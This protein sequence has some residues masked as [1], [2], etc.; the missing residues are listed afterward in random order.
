MP[1]DIFDGLLYIKSQLLGC[2]AFGRAEIKPILPEPDNAGVGK[3][4]F[5]F[6]QHF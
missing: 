3:R 4:C 1:D 2:P 5:F 6:F